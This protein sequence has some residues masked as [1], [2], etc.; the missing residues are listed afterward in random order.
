MNTLV[1]TNIFASRR[2]AYNYYHEL[3]YSREDTDKLIKEG[4]IRISLKKPEP[5]ALLNEEGRWIVPL[6][7]EY[8]DKI[9]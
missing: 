2:Q 6:K 8:Y 9:K 3:G 7:E 4:E 5:L 1:G